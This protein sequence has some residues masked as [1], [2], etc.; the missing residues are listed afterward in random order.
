MTNEVVAMDPAIV[1]LQQ[2]IPKMANDWAERL[3]QLPE[4]PLDGFGR[5]ELEDTL[6]QVLHAMLGS[7]ASAENQSDAAR[8][9]GA[10]LRITL[11][12]TPAQALQALLL[13]RSAMMPVLRSVYEGD[14]TTAWEAI[15][16]IDQ[17][18]LDVAASFM[19]ASI[20]EAQHRGV[21][22]SERMSMML[23]VIRAAMGV[24]DLDE[25]LM[26]IQQEIA[27]VVSGAR[28]AFYLLDERRFFPPLVPVPQYPPLVDDMISEIIGAR[29]PVA[30][31]DASADPRVA[32]QIRQVA[33][34]KSSLGVPLILRDRVVGV[35]LVVTDQLHDF[36]EEEIDLIQALANPAALAIENVLLYREAQ[37]V[38]IVDE[39]ARIARDL[40]DGSNQLIAAA[41]F[42]IQAAQEELSS[43]SCEGALAE[44]R[45]V[46]DVLGQV[47]SQNRLIISGLHLPSVSEQGL[48]PAL[49]WYADS[50][51]A[52]RRI[53]CTLDVVGRV[54][55]L[56]DEQA[57]AAYRVVQEALNNAAAHAQAT[58]VRIRVAFEPGQMCVRVEDDGRGF[59]PGREPH[60][61]RMGLLSMRERARTVD[62][63]LEVESA[64]GEGTLV[65]I[66][67][68]LSPGSQRGRSAGNGTTGDGRW[69]QL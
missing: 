48:I 46:K 35:V 3:L 9:A 57:N 63:T 47:A 66:C 64:P 44:L 12:L 33:G 17:T 18:M 37:Q 6:R 32:Q 24:S 28:G 34:F 60:P 15:G 4:A 2:H 10:S 52:R 53:P 25:A 62:G 58:S 49:Q 56:A 59:D 43:G 65:E 61:G 27:S 40:H 50:F 21:E 68:P 42:G 16:G 54:A 29:K 39:R 5:L 20:D 55:R 36:T 38:A 69:E 67:M 19:Q 30:S 23:R 8:S 22:H 31:Y 51:A 41:L 7:F 13:G 1:M 11:R 26:H 45:R 14:P